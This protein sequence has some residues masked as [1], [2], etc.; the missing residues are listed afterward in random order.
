ME[1]NRFSQQPTRKKRNLVLQ[2]NP[3]SPLSK[4]L[5]PKSLNSALTMKATKWLAPNSRAGAGLIRH[6][7]DL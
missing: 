7:R 5:A 3:R 4:Q 6:D 2:S 1:Q